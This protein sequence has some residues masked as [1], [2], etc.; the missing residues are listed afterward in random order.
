[1]SGLEVLSGGSSALKNGGCGRGDGSA[2]ELKLGIVCASGVHFPGV[3]AIA[4]AKGVILLRAAAIASGE[5]E[6][7]VP[8]DGAT[9][10][11]G[12]IA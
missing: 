1:M 9:I 6:M 12:M 5:P 2:E 10:F 4:S 8:E 11:H 3:V 7:L